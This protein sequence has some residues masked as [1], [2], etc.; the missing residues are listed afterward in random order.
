MGYVGSVLTGW[1][2]TKWPEAEIYGFDSALFS[3]CLTDASGIPER[4]LNTQH[5]GDVRAFPAALLRNVDQVVYLA[6]ISNDPMGNRFEHATDEINHTAGIAIAEMARDNGVKSFVFASSCSMYGTAEGDPRKETDDLCPLTAYARSKVSTEEDLARMPLG[7]MT[8]TALRF[9]TACG[10]SPR[11]RLDLVLNDF[12]ASAVATGEITVL[13]DGSPWRPLIDVKDMSRAIEW[14]I[15]RDASNG[16]QLVRANAGSNLSNYQVRDLAERVAEIVPNTTVSINKEAPPDKRSYKVDFSLYSRLAP[17][18]Q[19]AIGL[20]QSIAEIRTGLVNI[21]F[22]DASFR[23]SQL[24]RLK[25]LE[26]H[27]S[28]GLLDDKLYWR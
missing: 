12:V 11:L 5:F 20:R 9:A 27:I 24:M 7:N 23:Q 25:V 6:A 8:V 16:G 3:H 1:L 18:H 22:R 15:L 28:G 2:R 21:G 14:A 26:S 19:P 4:Q 17:E 13:S 10:M